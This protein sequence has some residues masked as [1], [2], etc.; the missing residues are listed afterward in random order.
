M[1]DLTDVRDR[2]RALV[3]R[4]IQTGEI[5][6]ASGKVT[7]FYF[8]GR[9]VSLSPEGAFLMSRL[10][11]EEIETRQITAIGGPTSGAD[12]IVS[13]VGILAYQE[14]VDLQ[15]FYVRKESKGAWHAEAA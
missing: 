3:Q 9:T 1:T 8:D 7:D 12:P 10:I 2:L 14:G 15:L 4:C 13:S 5:T 6:L 11:L